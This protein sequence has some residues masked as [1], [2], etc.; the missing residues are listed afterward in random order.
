VQTFGEY[1]VALIGLRQ[2]FQR[3]RPELPRTD[4]DIYFDQ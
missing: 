1:Y 2:F 4:V 3:H